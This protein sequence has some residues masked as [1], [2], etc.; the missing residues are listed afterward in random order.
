MWRTIRV[1]CG[2]AWLAATK[3]P[4]DREK[5][6]LTHSPKR[7]ILAPSSRRKQVADNGS[8]ADQYVVCRSTWTGPHGTAPLGACL[9]TTKH[10]TARMEAAVGF[11]FMNR[12][13]LQA[14]IWPAMRPAEPGD[15]SLPEKSSVLCP[16]GTYPFRGPFFARN[17]PAANWPSLLFTRPWS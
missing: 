17:K 12:R 6:A 10:T 3:K 14:F 11:D 2:V 7:D 5:P 13:S 8:A 15:Q 1:E 9:R 16:P 4:A